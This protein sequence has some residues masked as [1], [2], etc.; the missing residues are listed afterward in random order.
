ME[1]ETKHAC[2]VSGL[3][4]SVGDATHDDIISEIG[5]I[6]HYPLRNV[7]WIQTGS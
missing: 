6:R 3:I 4:D 1:R 5:E 2:A 7:E